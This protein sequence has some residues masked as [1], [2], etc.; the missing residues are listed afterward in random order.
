VVDEETPIEVAA[1]APETVAVAETS[2]PAAPT[3]VQPLTDQETAEFMG[4]DD[5]VVQF[6]SDYLTPEEQARYAE[7]GDRFDALKE[8]GWSFEPPQGDQPARWTPPATV[9]TTPAA[10]AETPVAPAV[11]TPAAAPVAPVTSRTFPFQNRTAEGMV[12]NDTEEIIAFAKSIA[13][14][15]SERGTQPKY[16]IKVDRDVTIDAQSEKALDNALQRIL[17]GAPV[18]VFRN[19]GKGVTLDFNEPGPVTPAPAAAPAAPRP[20]PAP[21]PAPAPSPQNPLA[22][23]TV[24]FGKHSN[25]L[26]KDLFAQQPDYAA[27]LVRSTRSAA[28]RSPMRQVGDYINSLPEYQNAVTEEKAKAEAILTDENQSFLTGLKI[29]AQQNPDGSI[30]LR[31]KTYDRQ[32]DLRAAGGRY[33]K[34]S[35]TYTISAAGLGQFIERSRTDPGTTGGQRSGSPAYSRDVEL[36]KLREDADNRPDRSG[37]DGGVDNYLSVETQ[38]LIRQGEDFGIPRE[39]GDEQIEDAALMVQAFATKRPFFMLSSAPGTGKTFVLGAGIREMQDRFARKIIYVTLNR[40][41]IKQIQQ[42]LKAYNLGPVKFITYSEMKDLAPEE[43]DVLIF[44]EAHAIKN[45]A[46]AGSDQA[47]KAQEWIQQVPNLLDCNAVREPD[48][49]SLPAEHWNL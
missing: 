19:A 32:D 17:S 41:L 49:D 34:D 33:S 22:N 48:S 10:P 11:P 43:S 36:R 21:R 28:P 24:G 35:R 29:T 4:L 8:S 38:E 45:L 3:E 15:P 16:T 6:G 37:L 5:Q 47:K 1:V 44:D 23:Q 13:G 20:T 2:T 40:G 25:L 46:G 7:L 30:T 42:D 18:R 26:V 27:W 14:T 31:G 9:P 12:D 39:V